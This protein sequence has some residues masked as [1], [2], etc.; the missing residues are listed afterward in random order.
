[1]K[2]RI[3]RQLHSDSA[4]GFT[5]YIARDDEGAG[6]YYRAEIDD[7]QI[8]RGSLADAEAAA[9]WIRK[10]RGHACSDTC[11]RGWERLE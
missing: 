7:V 2:T 5:V 10:D 4:G 9:K 1:M 6:D 8:A 3:L 11:S